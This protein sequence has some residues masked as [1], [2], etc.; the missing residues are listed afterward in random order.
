MN[1]PSLE[2]CKHVLPADE[3][4]TKSQLLAELGR[5]VDPVAVMLTCSDLSPAPDLVSRLNLGNFMFLQ[6]PGGL[7]PAEKTNDGGSCIVSIAYL[8]N[9]PTVRHL[10]VCGHTECTTLGMIV[11][12]ET[13]GEKHPYLKLMKGVSDQFYATYRDRP[14]QEWLS[15]IVQE[16]VLQQIANLRS[17]AHI[18]SLLRKGKLL[19]Q[20]WIRDDQT[21]VITAYDPV[22]GQFCN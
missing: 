14:R 1:L 2:S 21:S 18:Q 3:F 9:M 4:G 8:L 22:A 7:F 13:E 6:N 11:A 16:N 5:G 19:F 17:Y 20:G 12:Q 15:I 10:I